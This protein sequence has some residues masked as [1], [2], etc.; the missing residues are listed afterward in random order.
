MVG[1][2]LEGNLAPGDALDAFHGA[3]DDALF[4]EHGPLLDMQLHEG[5]HL[6]AGAGCLASVT[7]AVEV[8][9]DRAA[10]DPHRLQGILQR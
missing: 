10:V 5:M 9:A 3:D 6:R 2:T 7:D 8:F 4:L 1:N